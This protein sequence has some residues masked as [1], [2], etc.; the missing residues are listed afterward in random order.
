M[1]VGNQFCNY[2][3][4]KPP[5][6]CEEKVSLRFC[7]ACNRNRNYLRLWVWAWVSIQTHKHPAHTCCAPRARVIKHKP[8]FVVCC[9]WAPRCCSSIRRSPP[10]TT[11]NS[12]RYR[13]TTIT[14]MT[15][16]SA[17]RRRAA[18]AAHHGSVWTRRRSSG[19]SMPSRR[20]STR[21][22]RLHAHKL[23]L[24]L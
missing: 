7:A 24:Y 13:P 3:A 6:W 12:I 1:V 15:S 14:T 10:S 20:R 23:Y 21:S 2:N 19:L 5:Y 9:S 18:P 4:L 11:R 8:V 17:G 22:A 16:S